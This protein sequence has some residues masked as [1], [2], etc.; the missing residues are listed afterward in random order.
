MKNKII[1]I[2]I[3]FIFKLTDFLVIKSIKKSTIN[4][5]VTTI[6]LRNKIPYLKKKLELIASNVT[7]TVL[8]VETS[9]GGA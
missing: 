1:S 4:L 7:T 5:I 3:S 2:G 8:L 6:S 9:D